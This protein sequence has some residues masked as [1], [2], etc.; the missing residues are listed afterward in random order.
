MFTQSCFIRK[1]TPELREQLKNL[2]YNIDE[3]KEAECIATSHVNSKAVGISEDSFDN[4]NPHRTW[5]CAGRIDC[6]DNDK[7]FLALAAL[8]DDSDKNQW[9]VLD[10]N[11]GED[12]YGF[13]KKG[14]FHFCK[15]DN[16]NIYFPVG[17]I[18]HKATV[19]ELIKHFNNESI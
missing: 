5:N 10:E 1:N 13:L 9:F 19:N 2:G 11:Y 15:K 12:D 3:I 14:S 7:L 16:Y 4:I 8:R 17:F 18:C 6:K